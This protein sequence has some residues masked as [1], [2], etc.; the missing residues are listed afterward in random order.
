MDKGDKITK[1]SEKDSVNF[2]NRIIKLKPGEEITVC[3]PK[4][5]DKIVKKDDKSVIKEPQHPQ[6]KSIGVIAESFAAVIGSFVG[7]IA[8]LLYL[9]LSLVC[10]VLNTV[11]KKLL[12]CRCNEESST[13]QDRTR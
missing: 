6:Q 4:D 1:K 2:H 12:G 5:D 3:F 13:T 8:A 11:S 7:I 10:F 9:L